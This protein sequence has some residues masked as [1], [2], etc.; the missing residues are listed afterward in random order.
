[1]RQEYECDDENSPYIQRLKNIPPTNRE[2][3][4]GSSMA[5]PSDTL[6]IAT[7]LRTRIS[8]YEQI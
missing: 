7:Y 2:V 5:F 6:H 4:K 3:F 8:V 1:M